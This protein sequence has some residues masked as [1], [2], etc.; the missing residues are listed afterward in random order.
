MVQDGPV[1][2]QQFRNVNE[3]MIHCPLERRLPRLVN[4]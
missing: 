4:E 2:E 3:V 1:S